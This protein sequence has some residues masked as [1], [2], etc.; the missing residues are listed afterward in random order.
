MKKYLIIFAMLLVAL[1]LSAPA[2]LARAQP[3]RSR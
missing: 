1:F 2:H 3:E